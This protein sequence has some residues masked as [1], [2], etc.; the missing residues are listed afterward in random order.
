M[1]HILRTPEKNFSDLTDYPFEANYY[2]WNGIRV[3]YVD[4]G[5]KKGPVMLLLHGM[6][7]WRRVLEK[8]F[9]PFTLIQ[10]FSI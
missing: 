9:L 8:V 4:E 5:P 3:H 1:A 6:P 7:T 2:L 10:Y